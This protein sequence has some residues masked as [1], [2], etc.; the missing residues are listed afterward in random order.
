MTRSCISGENQ[1]GRRDRRLFSFKALNGPKKQPERAIF[2][3]LRR[4]HFVLF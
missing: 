4:L 1:K 2:F 3:G